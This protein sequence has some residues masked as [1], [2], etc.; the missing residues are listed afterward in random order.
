MK[1]FFQTQLG[2]EGLILRVFVGCVLFGH[3]AQKLFGWFGGHG[4][5]AAMNGLSARLPVVLVFILIILESL[6]S[7]GLIVG[8][9][10]RLI[11]LGD[12]IFMIGAITMV[13]WPNGFFI[14]WSGHQK[15]EG[16]EYHLLV[17]G[18]SLA[19]LIGGA[20]KASIDRLIA[21]KNEDGILRGP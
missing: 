14:N 1:K 21:G 18:I 19:L 2:W 15:G 4:F 12:V 10:T 13:H 17:L 8:F 9:M 3:G 5:T 16:F 20:G 11:A 7:L 6:G